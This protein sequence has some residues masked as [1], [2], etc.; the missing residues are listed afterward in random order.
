[1]KKKLMMLAVLLGALSL[2]ACVDNNESA[3]VEAVRNAKA[4]QLKGLAA[5]AN[6]QAEATKITAEAE[7]AL[8]NAQAEYQ[9]EMT[10][11]AKQK[12]AVDIE[13]I[14]AEAEKA[15]AEAKKAASEAELLILKNADERVQW[16][17]G[18]YT[19]A[20]GELATL[21]ENLLTKTAG[22]AQLEAGITTAEANAKINTITLNR[23][24]AAETAKL[25]VLKDPAN[26]NIDK[27]AL[28]AKKAAVYQ[29]YELANSTV[30]NNEGAALNAD[31]KGIQEAIDALDRDAIDVVNALSPYSGVVQF[32]GLENLYWEATTGPAYRNISSGAYISEVQKLNAVN[33]FATDLEDAA[34]ELGTSADT[35]DK[36]TA[37]GRLAAANAQ[38]EDANKM[39]ETTDAEKAA[40]EQAIK[41]AKK[42]IALA[43]DGIVRAQASYDGKKT[44]SDEFTAA[45]AAVDV[46]AYND[47]VSAIVALVK[48][49]E[50]VAKAFNDANETPMKLWNEYSVLNTLYDNSQNLE[51]LIARCEYNIAYAK[52]RIKFYEVNITSAEAQLAKEK[53]ELA[54]LEKE[55]AAKKIIV[56]NAKAALDA[57]LN[58]E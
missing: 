28:N 46:K 10:E 27:D 29:K 6:A 57:E 16:L 11:E 43:E 40:K 35:K 1:M 23:S 25:E 44:A 5:L 3:S 17:Y 45:L 31:A 2:G 39:G 49:N 30:M 33:Y 15:I 48:A 55:I 12:F 42:A 18:Q 19:I 50:T 47:A 52:E 41:D 22:L 9:K 21:N 54:N 36:D 34:K 32:T 38:L 58:A 51:E 7:A 37:Y 20:A 24:I 56:D 26:A 13:K 53:E 8:K 14:K 4:E